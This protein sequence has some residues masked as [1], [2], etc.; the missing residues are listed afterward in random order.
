MRMSNAKALLGYTVFLLAGSSEAHQ[1]WYEQRPGRALSLYYGEYDKNMLEVTPGGMD[2][3][4]QLKGWS[5]GDKSS[6]LNLTSQRQ[7]FAVAHQAKNDDSPLAWDVHYP[8]FDLHEAGKTLKTYWTPA[9][10]WVGDLRARTPELTLDIVPTGQ[11][12]DNKAQFQVFYS[13]K[14]VVDQNVILEIGSA[15]SCPGAPTKP[16]RSASICPCRARMWWRSNTR[17]APSVNASVRTARP[18]RMT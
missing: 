11:V 4:Q 6:P 2:R 10:R 13:K 17:I 3:F 14:P 5:V 12:E 18:S 15:K 7:A 16:A 1:I 8:I 9:T